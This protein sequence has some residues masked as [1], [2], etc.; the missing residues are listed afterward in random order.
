MDYDATEAEHT[1]EFK[2]GDKQII[3]AYP[4]KKVCIFLHVVLRREVKISRQLESRRSCYLGYC[5]RL[6]Y[7]YGRILMDKLD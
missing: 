7:F 1:F 6:R 3:A 4:T 2:V 5:T